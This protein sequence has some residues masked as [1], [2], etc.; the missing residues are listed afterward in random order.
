MVVGDHSETASLLVKG[1]L[2]HHI[3]ETDVVA[4]PGFFYAALDVVPEHFPWW[5][6][7]DRA[8]KMFFERVVGELQAFLRSV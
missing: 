4:N 3:V 1:D 6:G 5:I 2:A 8:T 7:A